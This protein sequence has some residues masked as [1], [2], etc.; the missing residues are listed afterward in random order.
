MAAVIQSYVDRKICLLLPVILLTESCLLNQKS[1]TKKTN[2]FQLAV[3]WR[4]R[5]VIENFL[6]SEPGR[7]GCL[8]FVCFL[9]RAIF[10]GLP[11]KDV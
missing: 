9:F 7:T 3:I 2:G 6:P 4:L 1:E 8:D 10:S 5:T 11:G